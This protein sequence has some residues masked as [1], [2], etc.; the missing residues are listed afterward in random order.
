MMSIASS[1]NALVSD[2]AQYIHTHSVTRVCTC[3]EMLTQHETRCSSSLNIVYLKRYKAY[4]SGESDEKDT[5]ID[6][7]EQRDGNCY[8]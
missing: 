2:G 7:S 8:Q 6:V 1:V 3:K 5:E 4:F